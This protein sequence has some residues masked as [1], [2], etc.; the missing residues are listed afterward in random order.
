MTWSGPRLLQRQR[1]RLNWAG[2]TGAG[3]LSKSP[4]PI[5]YPAAR[6]KGQIMKRSYRGIFAGVH[7]MSGNMRS[8]SERKTRRMWRPNVHVMRL[9][10]AVL[11]RRLELPVSTRALRTIDKYGGVDRYLLRQ[12]L[13]RL[14]EGVTREL[15][16]AMELTLLRNPA[17]APELGLE[18]VLRR[19]TS[20]GKEVARLEAI[21]AERAA[22]VARSREERASPLPRL[23]HMCRARDS[24][25]ELARMAEEERQARHEEAVRRKAMRDYWGRTTA[26]KEGSASPA[27]AA[28]ASVVPVS[29]AQA[30]R[31]ADLRRATLQQKPSFDFP[32][33]MLKHRREGFV[34]DVKQIGLR[35]KMG[36]I[37]QE[38][39]EETATTG[40]Q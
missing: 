33:Y 17:L 36:L 7:I 9:D 1:R 5:D 21:E 35:R 11:N 30:R 29:K 22:I 28:S 39:A 19:I 6:A 38:G 14:D 12:Q 3:G 16:T 25:E 20:N 31:D 4:D 23:T 10:S 34:P 15:R 2:E 32:F 27:A 26:A 37:P 18:D 13:H 40:Q 8:H 24:E